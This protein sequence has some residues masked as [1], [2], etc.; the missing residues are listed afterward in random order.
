MAAGS[1]TGT[2]YRRPCAGHAEPPGG[3]YRLPGGC[4]HRCDPGPSR[5]HRRSRRRRARCRQGSRRGGAVGGIRRAVAHRQA[6]ARRR[7]CRRPRSPTS[8]S[9]PPTATAE[10][11]SAA[12][13]RR[14]RRVDPRPPA[15]LRH[16]QG[17]RRQDVG[18]GRARASS[19][20]QS[21]PAHAGLRDG[22]QG[23]AGGR[24]RCCAARVRAPP[25][26]SRTCSRW[27]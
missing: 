22:C 8:R 13:A 5:D 6:R 9:A 27:R 3:R 26:S 18:R 24:V 14:G 16:R 2:T 4:T 10:S 25:R 11:D 15:R 19:S 21:G 1:G 23:R 7:R 17:W 20:A 12:D